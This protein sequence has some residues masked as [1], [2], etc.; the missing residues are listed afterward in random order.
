MR[1]RQVSLRRAIANGHVLQEGGD[2][3][4]L[5]QE[6]LA[7]AAL[8]NPPEPR[9]SRARPP[10]PPG[11]PLS[12]RGP[13]AGTGTPR[14][15]R[16]EPADAAAETPKQVSAGPG[17]SVGLSGCPAAAGFSTPSC[18]PDIRGWEPMCGDQGA[19][20][21]TFIRWTETVVTDLMY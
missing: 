1:G 6:S 10:A 18:S 20:H 4:R 13:A 15:R 9:A 12:G 14:K 3:Y 19:G 17:W 21:F 16:L 11:T 2:L 8:L 7:V 5:P